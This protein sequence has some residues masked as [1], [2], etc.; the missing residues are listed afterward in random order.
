[1]DNF[2][3]NNYKTLLE[4]DGQQY[5]TVKEHE[6]IL[7]EIINAQITA[8]LSGVSGALNNLEKA[9]QDFENKVLK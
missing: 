8:A 6:K 4:V 7:K 1:M 9:T 2:K 3:E 5:I